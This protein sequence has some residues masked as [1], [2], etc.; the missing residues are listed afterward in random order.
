MNTAA[1][2]YNATYGL[3]P[4][5]AFTPNCNGVFAN[6]TTSGYASE[7]STVNLIAGNT[8]TFKSSIA[9]DY[10]TVDNNG[11]APLVGVVGVSTVNGISWTCTASGAYRF[12]T[13]TSSS[14]G[15]ST[16]LRTRS[17]RC[18][19]VA[20]PAP[21]N[22]LVANATSITCGSNTAG[23]TI[24]STNTGT[25]E[26]TTTCGVSQGMPGVWYKVAGNGQTMTASLCGTAWDSK[27]NV[28]SGTATALTCIG[29][30]D[31]GGPACGGTPASFAFTTVSGTDYFIKVSG[32]ST[33][34]AFTLG[35]TCVTPPPPAVDPC[36]SITSLSCGTAS[37]YSLTGT[38]GAW[39]SFGGPFTT[40]GDEQVFSFT[41][42]LTGVHTI[43][44]TANEN[45]VDLFFKANSCAGSTGWTYVDDIFGSASNNVTLTAGVTYYFLLDDENTTAT[46]GNITV[47]C[48]TPASNP[49]TSIATISGCAASATSFSIAAGDGLWSSYG[50]PYTTPGQEKI[51]SFT[52][53]TSA[54]YAI[55]VVNNGPSTWVDLFWK[56]A[57]VGC[58]NTGWTYVDDVLGTFTNNVSFTAGVTYYIMLDPE[59][60]V[61][62]SGSIQIGCPDSDGDGIADNV[63]ACPTVYGTL[64]NG[65]PCIGAAVDGNY[66]YSS[67]LAISGTTVDACDN[68]TL[69][70][71]YDMTYAITIPCAGNYTFS[72]CGGASWDTYLFLSS[73]VNSGVIASNDDFCSL[74]SQISAN[75]SAGTYY[76]T[77]EPFSSST[78]GAFTLNVSG[79]GSTP[80]ITGSASNATCFGA[81]NG[82]I[83][84]T[85]NGNGNTASATLNGASFNGSASGLAA[86][87]YTL[88]ASNCWGTSSQTFTV[89]QPAA[90]TASVASNV[91]NAAVCMGGGMTLTGTI[92]GN[93]TVTYHWEQ[94]DD[95][96]GWSAITNDVNA[97]AP[98]TV[99]LDLADLSASANYQLV[100]TSATDGSCSAAGEIAVTVV[101]DPT[102][103]IT[104]AN[105][106]CNGGS[107]GA[108]EAA[109]SGGLDGMNYT[110]DF[111]PSVSGL[112]A[113]TYTMNA[114]GT[115]GCDVSAVAEISEPT[116]LT[117]A[118]T[119]GSIACNGGTT[120]VSVSANGGTAPY[121]G[122]GTFTVSAGAYSYTVTDANGCTSTTSITVSEPTALGASNVASDFNG[123]GVSCNGGSNGSVNVSATGGTAPYSGD[124]AYTNLSAGN[125]S[126]TV[127]DANG[128]TASTSATITEPTAVSA[129]S[130]TSDYNGSG[131]SC[132]GSSNGSITVSA[133]GG[134]A[135][136]V[137]TGSYNNLS[138]GT[139]SYT[140]TDANG[141]TASTSATITEPTVLTSASISGSIAC[142]GGTTTVSVSA[143]GG[144]APYSG[145]G[146]Y[147]VGAGTYFY[148][149]TDAN[150]CASTTSITVIEPTAVQ[151][152]V[153]AGQTVFY[154]YTPMAC[155]TISGSATGGTPGYTYN[156][157]SN[158]TTN[159]T[160]TSLTVC[161][162]QSTTYTLTATD[163]LGCTSSSDV[164]IC[165]VDVRC[166]AGNS[167]KQKVQMCQTP[168]GNPANAHTICVDA[169]AV[170]AHLAI[171]CVLG[172]CGEL[173]SACPAPQARIQS[174]IED[175]LT[176][177]LS[178]EDGLAALTVY[179]NPTVD[180]TSVSLTVTVTGEYNVVLYNT[181]G[182]VVETIYNGSIAEFEN[183]TFDLNMTSLELGVY[184]LSVSNGDGTIETVR[185]VKQ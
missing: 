90:L 49:C 67:P 114:T 14:C 16:S 144:T 113:G 59:S 133:A 69:R 182:Q 119:S 27:I 130:T 150:G 71:G 146:N 43:D 110:W 98:A 159:G 6:V 178:A 140:V 87:T 30:N 100:V 78:T 160:S 89:G 153:G 97:A 180:R 3:W 141:C 111:G 158:G 184:I 45:Y 47:S 80:S 46:S 175:G 132:N 125:Y 134:V 65:C 127:T 18:A 120:T 177:D 2:C 161:P 117:S 142:N 62:A 121:S 54:T 109:L 1:Q 93:T 138:A 38:T 39:S 162:T 154:G 10:I 41:P 107:N 174:T 36:A 25:Y 169:S 102:I 84:A 56:Q 166:Y 124:V 99:S 66:N 104:T 106:S 179:P 88:S 128:C 12:Y 92:G 101:E 63:D 171:G 156:W 24:N 115:L 40:P 22:D 185:V 68:S 118:S 33:N 31:D 79:T 42:T 94:Y 29:G 28:Y 168:P 172:A 152:T 8:Y 112:S 15:A 91:A 165:V 23:T 17:V 21:A 76:L 95:F 72:A 155:A 75:L 136:Y 181:I 103:A 170:P 26:G 50:G 11:A 135:P 137:A 4:S 167:N 123:Y 35:L 86:G 108:I 19:G 58:N 53:T 116:V 139:Y 20:A 82:S 73:A 145:T 55:T 77:V 183:Q 5:T 96:A 151:T 48:P 176:T 157:S 147:T 148:T 7:Y 51:F 13:H 122:T 60:N 143:A 9:T 163:A 83:T 70:A 173:A 105:V 164:Y 61:G 57:S 32:F 34:L 44:V 52:P 81:S 85:V 129:S 37:S 126:Y 74:Q 149:V 64:A 131:V